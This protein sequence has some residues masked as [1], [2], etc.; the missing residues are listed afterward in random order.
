M[1]I[2]V[3]CGRIV[4]LDAFAWDEYKEGQAIQ[5]PF[6]ELDMFKKQEK[7]GEETSPW[8]FEEFY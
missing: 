2:C 1:T 3:N 4:M 6:C 7:T 5:C 8:Y